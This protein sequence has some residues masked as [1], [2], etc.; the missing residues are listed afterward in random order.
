MMLKRFLPAI[1]LAAVL[2]LL[3]VT[4]A[5]AQ[6]DEGKP[7]EA[8]WR[9]SFFPFPGSLGN[10]FPLIAMH[11]EERKAADYYARTPYA[12]ILSLD[13]GSGFTG[14]RMAV[15][16]F[17]APL[18]WKG[19][20]LA[21]TLGTTRESRLGY[22][23]LGNNTVN[24]QSLVTKGQKH[25]YEAR[26]ARYFGGA[27][28]SRRIKGPL[29][30]AAGGEVEYSNLSDLSGPSLFRTEIGSSDLSD[31]DVRGRVTLVLDTRDNEFNTTR[32]LFAQASAGGGTGGDGYGRVT[33]DLRGYLPLREGTV[34]AAR[35]AGASM[36]RKASLNA[37]LELPVWEGE[38]GVLGGSYSNRGL[39]VQRFAGRGALMGS[40][41]V[42][43]DLLNLGDLG[44]LTLLA[45][46][47][48]GRVFEQERFRIT[49]NDLK[50][51]GGG[52]VALRIMR[53]TILTFNFATGPDG[54][55]FNSGTGWSF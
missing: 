37:R 44:A 41:E 45:F 14:A 26:R 16:R 39:Q 40:A 47:D 53:F 51:G 7:N 25:F 12:G 29:W 4:P 52:G 10:N 8:P 24:D 19:W 27:T 9:S 17:H 38:I 32:G 18:L 55:E 13:I 22:F 42:R 30:L 35:L 33:A 1:V 21:A 11:V 46:V 34:F 31:T 54:F 2:A 20:R 28:L 50:V 5:T 49:T 43:H 15:A 6:Q 36:S 23:G 48:V 3:P